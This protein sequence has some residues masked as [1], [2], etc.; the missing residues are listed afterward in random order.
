[1]E[2][3]VEDLQIISRPIEVM[4]LESCWLARRKTF[5]TFL[6]L[7]T[8]FPVLAGAYYNVE[9][10]SKR[11]IA[12]LNFTTF[13]FGGG[14]RGGEPWIFMVDQREVVSRPYGRMVS[15]CYRI[16]RFKRLERPSELLGWF[17]SVFCSLLSETVAFS[18]GSSLHLYCFVAWRVMATISW[19]V[20]FGKCS[21]VS[22][23]GTW[24][25]D[26]TPS[27]SYSWA[28]AHGFQHVLLQK[29]CI[30]LFAKWFISVCNL[31]RHNSSSC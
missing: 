23:G 2:V 17:P 6:T 21:M 25:V 30:F 26:W 3:R 19:T 15:S 11:H 27:F 18:L 28:V 1:M 31:M 13:Q 20:K 4:I 24:L 12:V 7:W 16:G 9:N 10:R 8:V 5:W 22:Q 29:L 14:A